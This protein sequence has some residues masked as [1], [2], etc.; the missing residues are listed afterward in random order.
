MGG[1]VWLGACVVSVWCSRALAVLATGFGAGFGLLPAEPSR[2]A[3]FDVAEWFEGLSLPVPSPSS[4]VVC[5]GFGCHTRTIIA[6]TGADR[7]ALANMVRGATPDAERRGLARAIAWFDRR[8]GRQTGTTGAKAYARGLA[9][10]ASQFDCVDRA[11]NTTSLLVVIDQWKLLQ[12]HEVQKP[13]SRAF[14][15]IVE[16]PHTTA[17]VAERKSG[18]KWVL[19]PWTHNYAELP[20]VMP[21]EKWHKLSDRPAR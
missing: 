19:D 15:P 2:A 7:V 6:L 20:D 11:T 12:H 1:N 13:A 3:V 4:I 18:Q 9:G 21:L 10:D 5:H 8:V 16:G 17:V 14:I